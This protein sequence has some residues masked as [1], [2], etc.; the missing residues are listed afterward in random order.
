MAME[1]G[2]FPA[3]PGCAAIT[4][5]RLPLD[6]TLTRL[7]DAEAA[8]FCARVDGR[9]LLSKAAVATGVLLPLTKRVMVPESTLPGVA[10]KP[11]GVKWK[12]AVEP[13]TPSAPKLW[14]L[15]SQKVTM[16]RS[17]PF[18]FALA[19]K[20]APEKS[21]ENIPAIAAARRSGVEYSP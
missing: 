10:P 13:L 7:E 18:A 4:F 17:L 14:P 1:N 5:T 2:I 12:E 8:R 16:S 11:L 19:Y 15:V 3:L 9:V 6:R 20:P 21:R